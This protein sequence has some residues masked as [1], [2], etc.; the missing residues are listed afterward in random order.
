MRRSKLSLVHAPGTC[1][2]PAVG[3]GS[4]S[5]NSN[6][7][8][9]G[10]AK[11]KATRTGVVQEFNPFDPAER[12][13]LSAEKAD[14]WED[15]PRDGAC[16]FHALYESYR[17]ASWLPNAGLIESGPDM[18]SLI[19]DYIRDNGA[20]FEAH[21]AS[22]RAKAMEVLGITR[23]AEMTYEDALPVYCQVMRTY[24]EWGGHPEIDA[25]AMMLNVMVHEFVVPEQGG[26]RDT[27]L[28]HATF[29]PMQSQLDNKRERKQV[30][31]FVLILRD[32]HF[33][34]VAPEMPKTL[35]AAVSTP[36]SSAEAGVTV[37][38]RAQHIKNNRT[39]GQASKTSS[40]KNDMLKAMALARESRIKKQKG[41]GK[42]T[43]KAVEL[44]QEQRN[45]MAT[46]QLIQKMQQEEEDAALARKMQWE[47][48]EDVNADAE[49]G[50]RMSSLERQLREEEEFNADFEM[51]LRMIF[52][53]D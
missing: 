34:Y 47:D 37:R 35:Q 14:N 19:C 13:T 29:Y 50:L 43:L 40:D 52:S 44:T 2:G 53:L 39:K 23:M 8:Q 33:E 5:A 6:F 31:K 45:E 4:W 36:S 3:L 48:E 49:L 46:I 15:T 42:C 25:A 41:G 32:S 1:S 27:A 20:R 30:T 16:L 24:D 12:R 9:V 11:H 26:E 7:N 28:L 10:L 51:A 22:I 18:R 21:S 38:E 17:I